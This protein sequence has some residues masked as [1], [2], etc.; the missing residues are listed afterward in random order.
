MAILI[1][2]YL[3]ALL[4]IL[5]IFFV[6]FVDV[7]DTF[8]CGLVAGSN[9][10][11]T[12]MRHFLPMMLLLIKLDKFF[13]QLNGFLFFLIPELLLLLIILFIHFLQVLFVPFSILRLLLLELL[14]IDLILVLG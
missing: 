11:L 8:D 14:T 5:G 4:C 3:Q 7:I 9:V 13:L 2:L 6:L 1:Q 10:D 12:A